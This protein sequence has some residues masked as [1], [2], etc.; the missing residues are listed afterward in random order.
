MLLP[1]FDGQIAVRDK[2]LALQFRT[3]VFRLDKAQKRRA[4]V[5]RHEFLGVLVESF[6]IRETVPLVNAVF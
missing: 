1:V 3:D 2:R 6:K 4:V 5:L